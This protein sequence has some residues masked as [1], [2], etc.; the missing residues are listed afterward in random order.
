MKTERSAV[1]IPGR[2]VQ[3]PRWYLMGSFLLPRGSRIF[4]WGQYWVRGGARVGF[5][6][7][8]VQNVCCRR[9]PRRA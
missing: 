3:Q 5:Q 1:R 8:S 9:A 2:I 7:S 4:M 6:D